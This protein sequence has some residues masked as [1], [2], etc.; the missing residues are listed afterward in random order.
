MPE[1]ELVSDTEV[2]KIV[3]VPTFSVGEDHPNS[4]QH[5]TEI[6][7]IN[8]GSLLDQF[9]TNLASMGSIVL[10]FV[11]ILC[12][13]DTWSTFTDIVTPIPEY[14]F[15]RCLLNVGLCVL[16][17]YILR[18]YTNVEESKKMIMF[19]NL[20]GGI[21]IWEFTESLISST[22]GDATNL[23]FIFYVCCLLVSYM[24]VLYLERAHRVDVIQFMSPL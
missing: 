10:A 9:R 16:S 12:F 5:I 8:R 18:R 2:D 23:K 3:D 1:F 6:Y 13:W 21:G 4:P 7:P 20:L 22:F 15:F 24:I 11:V 19:G 14:L 17:T